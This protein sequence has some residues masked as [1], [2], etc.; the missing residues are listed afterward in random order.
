MAYIHTGEKHEKVKRAD[1]AMRRLEKDFGFVANTDN[2]PRPAPPADLEG[3]VLDRQARELQQAG[4][5]RFVDG[6][7]RAFGVEKPG[8][9]IK[10]VPTLGAHQGISELRSQGVPSEF[11]HDPNAKDDEV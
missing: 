11:L 2:R 3:R 1:S 6:V 4:V 10:Q 8:D 5:E 9:P 7:R